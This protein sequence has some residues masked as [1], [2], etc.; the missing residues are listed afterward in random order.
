MLIDMHF[1]SLRTK[2]SLILRNEEASKQL[3]V[4]Y[5]SA[6]D[7]PT[8]CLNHLCVFIV[9]GILFLFLIFFK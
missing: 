6:S 8:Y 4:C 2:L 5:L 9:G 7:K 3:E 1:R